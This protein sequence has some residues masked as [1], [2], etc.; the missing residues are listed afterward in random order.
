MISLL[1]REL[2]TIVIVVATASLTAGAPAIAHGVHAAFAHNADKVDNKHAVGAGASIA[3]AKGKLVA[4]GSNGKFAS[5]F[6]P[7]VGA[8]VNADKLGNVAAAQYQRD[9]E[10]VV[11]VA[12]SGGDFTSIQAAVDSVT[13]ATAEARYLVYVAP[14]EYQGR[15][16]MK[17][18]VDLAGAGRDNTRIV[19]AGS[20]DP[21][22]GSVILMAAGTSVSSLTV[23]QTG[24]SAW[25]IFM[26]SD[27]KLSDVRV[28][29][30]IGSGVR[31]SNL[32]ED[33]EIYAS[34]RGIE[35]N[36]SIPLTVV[37]TDIVTENVGT[38][39]AGVDAGMTSTLRFLGG[40]VSSSASSDVTAISKGGLVGLPGDVFIRDA[41]LSAS[42]G[43]TSNTG[44]FQSQGDVEVV[45]S[46]V[47][48]TGAGAASVF[49]SDHDARLATSGL[50]G[51]VSTTLGAT[52]TCVGVYNRSTY[53]ALSSVCA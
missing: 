30:L 24:S 6:I 26:S 22:A 27:G 21:T 3:Q 7:K 35:S 46:L 9:Y 12:K 45:N 32:I 1:R 19:H 49:I 37:D 29:S 42:G 11:V 47:S 43:S 8:A 16:E 4:T 38:A 20:S 40:S 15:V 53:A 50:V 10:G 17:D 33:S 44:I 34:R 5:K 31:A 52:K 2:K 14:G 28:L 13:G 25:G 36:S 41:E 23:E 51:P 48:A 39:S 18:N